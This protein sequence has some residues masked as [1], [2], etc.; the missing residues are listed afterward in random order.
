M[1]V[2]RYVTLVALVDLAGAMAGAQ[3]GDLLRSIAAVPSH[4]A[5]S[6]SSACS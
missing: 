2:V 1:I 6:S 3:F 4:A 5:P